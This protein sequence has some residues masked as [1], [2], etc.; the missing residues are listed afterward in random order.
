[1]GKRRKGR[2]VLL[3]SL[4]A[5]RLSGR[6]LLRCLE[7]QLGP[8]DSADASAAFARA[9]ALKIDAYGQ[10]AEREIGALLE[11]W[12]PER[13]G[14]LERLILILAVTE[15]RHSPEVP[16]KVVINEA[17]ELARRYCDENAVAFVNGILD[18][19]AG[20]LRRE[21]REELS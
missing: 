5:A 16:W 18:R 21:G 19:V 7:E 11:N 13:V 20:D 15:L 8:F 6:S 4:Y 14:V 10:T 2:E 17:C 9:L 3:Q 12:A 1:V